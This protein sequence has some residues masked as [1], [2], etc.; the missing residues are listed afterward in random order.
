MTK[1]M[2]GTEILLNNLN[3]YVD[4]SQV[5][6]IPSASYHEVLD[7]IKPNILWQH[8]DVDQPIV[9]N[10]R[11]RSFTDKLS[12]LVFV[13]GW[14]YGQYLGLNIPLDKTE[15]I[16]NAIEPI[17][18]L[19]KPEK[20]KLIYASTPYRGLDLLLDVF[21]DMGRDDVELDVYSSVV[22]YGDEFIKEVGSQFDPLFDRARNMKNVNYH[23]YGTNEE[24]RKAMQE[25]HILAYP[26]IFRETSCLVAIEAGAAGCQLVTTNYGALPETTSGFG[27]MIPLANSVPKLKADYRAA[28]EYA[29]DNRD[30]NLQKYQSDFFNRMYSWE[31]RVPEWERLLDKVLS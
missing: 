25:A 22:I 4:L 9:A 17:E 16:R 13:S 18:Y 1:P 15:I 28:L 10:M 31:A 6:V 2:G 21:E 20:K 7:P 14:Q 12:S 26:S 11:E 27:T 8:M 5:N 24:V 23:G 29:I 30:E 3:K 19:P